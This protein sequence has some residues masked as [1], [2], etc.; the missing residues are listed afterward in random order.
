MTFCALSLSAHGNGAPAGEK[1]NHQS[2]EAA[3]ATTSNPERGTSRKIFFRYSGVDRNYGKV[4]FV[5]AARIGFP[6]FVDGLRCEV[7]YVA[8][9]RGI[10]LGAEYRILGIFAATLFDARTFEVFGKVPV[11]G[12][13][14]RARVAM[15]G[16]I[17]ASTVFTSGHGYDSVNFSTQTLLIDIPSSRMIA[18]VE[19]FSVQRDGKPFKNKDFNFWGV[20]F[21]PDSRYFYATLST[22][23]QH[24]LIKGDIAA[25]SA[26]VIH[27]NVEC[28]S[29]S[30][31]GKR[32]AY[33]K[34]LNRPGNVTWQLHVL[35]LTSGKEQPLAEKRSV[36]DQLEWLNDDV[37]LY[38]LPDSEARAT[39]V[40]NVWRI[41]V[42]GNTLPALFLKNAYSPAVVR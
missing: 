22:Q 5:D 14:S 36:D 19:T 42:D 30:P 6:Q 8:G 21:S 20:T 37:L 18:D 25:R 24:L 29:L 13:P 34:R 35:D 3:D 32:I 31:D 10:C 33:K 11:K 38:T 17:A 1:L 26:V 39:P 27:E 23:R 7:V 41:E 2:H 15:N 28:P 40:T 4:A 9:E 12:L 16:K